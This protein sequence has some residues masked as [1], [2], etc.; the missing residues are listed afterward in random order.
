[1]KNPIKTNFQLKNFF[2][3][4]TLHS[5]FSETDDKGIIVDVNDNF[6]QISKYSRDELIG[7]DHRIVNSGEHSKAF[8]HEMWETIKSGQVWVGDIKNKAKDGTYYWVRTFINPTLNE[9]NHVTGFISIRNDITEKKQIEQKNKQLRELNLAM[10]EM[11]KIGGWELNTHTMES[12]WTKG[13]YDIYEIPYDRPLNEMDGLSFFAKYDQPRIEKCVKDC[14]QK[15]IRFDEEFDFITSK[16]KKIIVRSIGRPVFNKNGEI[17][18]LRGSFQDITEQKNLQI[19]VDEERLISLQKSKLATLGE[20]AAG[21]IHEINNPLSIA[22]SASNGLSKDPSLSE[23]GLAQIEKIK[24]SIDRI[25]KIVSSLGKYSHSTSNQ[26]Y[27]QVSLKGLIDECI[28]LT[29]PRHKYHFIKFQCLINEDIQLYLNE[30]QIVQVLINLINNAI[31]AIKE[32]NSPWIEFRFNRTENFDQIIVRD[33]GRGI[34][35]ENLKN[36]FNAFFTTKE[37]GKGTGLGLSISKRIAQEHG[38]DLEYRLIDG[39]TAFIL[40]L[41]KKE[42]LSLAG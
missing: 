1:M 37:A 28:D 8:F 22:K 15:G 25:V 19:Q 31:D 32:E 20:M 12:Y 16:G 30:N 35:E 2:E 10:Q 41:A 40:S 11:V 9:N 27:G 26:R 14:I 38:G 7:K 33:S 3:S 23:K 21:I 18:L 42:V 29:T 24:K 13:I 36:L 4:I 6:C 34:N 39:H 5:I 17:Y